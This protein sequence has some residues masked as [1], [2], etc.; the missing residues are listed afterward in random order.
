MFRRAWCCLCHLSCARCRSS[1]RSRTSSVG[2]GVRTRAATGMIVS[3]RADGSDGSEA[4]SSAGAGSAVASAH[5]SAGTAISRCGGVGFHFRRSSSWVRRRRII[6]DRCSHFVAS[7]RSSCRA[8]AAS[9]RRR[10]LAISPACS[11]AAASRASFSTARIVF[12]RASRSVSPSFPLFRS[13]SRSARTAASSSVSARVAR[14]AAS[15]EAHRCRSRTSSPRRSSATRSFSRTHSAKKSTWAASAS[16][17]SDSASAFI[18]QDS[19][20]ASAWCNIVM[21]VSILYDC[22]RRERGYCFR[23]SCYDGRLPL[24]REFRIVSDRPWV[25]PRSFV[26]WLRTQSKPTLLIT[27][28]VKR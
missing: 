5:F 15:S 2:V 7:I 12:R 24:W 17:R 11:S 9:S 23:V 27:S 4:S 14:S 10:R 8:S 28:S 21:C 6:W 13:A 19:A 18:R 20:S 22:G 3:Q 26:S 25:L 16:T 1:G